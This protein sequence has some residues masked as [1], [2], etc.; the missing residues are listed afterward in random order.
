MTNEFIVALASLRK[1]AQNQLP[2]HAQLNGNADVLIVQ[3]LTGG[4]TG[5]N[6]DG[7]AG[8]M[9][10]TDAIEWIEARWAERDPMH[11]PRTRLDWWNRR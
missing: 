2:P 1:A 3:H 8:P 10:L 9:T 6:V 4:N 7:L 11:A 5:V